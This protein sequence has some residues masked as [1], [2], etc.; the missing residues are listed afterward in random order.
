MAVQAFIMR[1]ELPSEERMSHRIASFCT[2]HA[3]KSWGLDLMSPIIVIYKLFTL[4]F[5][6]VTASICNIGWIDFR[7]KKIAL[8]SA[9]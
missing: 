8:P 2:S 7:E 6:L 4:L 3:K 9:T 5:L 1:W